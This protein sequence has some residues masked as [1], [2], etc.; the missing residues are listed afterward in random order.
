MLDKMTIRRMKYSDNRQ[1]MMLLGIVVVCSLKGLRLAFNQIFKG[2]R[3]KLSITSVICN[4]Y[5]SD[6]TENGIEEHLRI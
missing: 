5:G 2:S 1:N 6:D 3:N 4:M